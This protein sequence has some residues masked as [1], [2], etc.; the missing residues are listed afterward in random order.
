MT[1]ILPTI[2]VRRE[3]G[4]G[5]HIINLSDFDPA[6]HEVFQPEHTP[7]TAWAEEAAPLATPTGDGIFD[8]MSDEDLRDFIEQRTGKRPGGRSK[9]ETLIAKAREV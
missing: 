6:V 5:Y 8:D 3:G 9:R 2:T 7:A 1:S 4:R